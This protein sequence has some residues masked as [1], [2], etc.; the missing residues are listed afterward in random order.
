VQLFFILRIW[1]CRTHLLISLCASSCQLLATDAT[2]TQTIALTKFGV[3]ALALQAAGD[4]LI[5]VVL[6]FI[7]QRSR[8]GISQSESMIS[9]MMAVTM[10][11]GLL[12]SL[13][14]IGT[15]TALVRSPNSLTYSTLFLIATKLYSNSLFFA[16]NARNA[17]RSGHNRQP[18]TT[19]RFVS[20]GEEIAFNEPKGSSTLITNYS[21]THEMMAIGDV[22]N[23][24][25]NSGR[26]TSVGDA[27]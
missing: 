19:N 25:E 11:T 26:E 22:A 6:M 24:A 4:L 18:S 20:F 10:G 3:P 9:R 12:T 14:S 16:L 17:I 23:R 1:I 2:F 5:T 21:D 8:M 15:F 27:M 13:F 7:L